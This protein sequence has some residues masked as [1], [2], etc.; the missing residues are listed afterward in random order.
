[1]DTGTFLAVQWLRLWA[2]TAVGEGSVSGQ[3]TKIPYA[4]WCVQKKKNQNSN[5]NTN[6]SKVQ[7]NSSIDIKET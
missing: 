3:G 2:S 5:N 4:T 6:K 1:M 7:M